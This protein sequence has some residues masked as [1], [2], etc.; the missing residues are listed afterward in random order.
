VLA[1]KPTE[2]RRKVSAWTPEQLGSWLDAIEGHR[3]YP[4]FHLSAFAGLRRA[5]CAGL[6]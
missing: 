5:S 3:L 4:L 2:R 6:S 1:D